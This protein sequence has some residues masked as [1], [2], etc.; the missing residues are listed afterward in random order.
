MPKEK[1][2]AKI[3]GGSKL[4]DFQNKASALEKNIAAVISTLKE[5]EIP[6]LGQDGEEIRKNN[7]ASDRYGQGY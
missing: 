1:L 7:A 4:F 2:R 6:I 3:A 5:M